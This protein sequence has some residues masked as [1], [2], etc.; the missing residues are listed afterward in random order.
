[1]SISFHKEVYPGGHYIYRFP[2]QQVT[3]IKIAVASKKG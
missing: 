2:D 1:M 3:S